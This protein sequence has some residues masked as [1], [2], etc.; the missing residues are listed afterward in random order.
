NRELTAA[1]EQQTATAEVLRVIASTPTDLN[2]VLNAIVES[3]GRL[4][5]APEAF[6]RL[7]EGDQLVLVAARGAAMADFMREARP[8]P[9]NHPNMTGLAISRRQIVRFDDVNT[10]PDLREEVRQ[11][12]LRF[13]LLSMIAVP[14]LRGSEPL[15]AILLARTEAAPFSEADVALVESFA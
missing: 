5:G 3:A 1:L 9:I 12:C 2:R 10:S 7:I 6:M 14:L 15:G 4:C 13:G 11:T 8:T